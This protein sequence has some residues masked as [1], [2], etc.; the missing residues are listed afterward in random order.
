MPPPPPIPPCGVG[1]VDADDDSDDDGAPGFPP[2][3]GDA[4]GDTPALAALPSV[5]VVE[6]VGFAESF[7][8]SWAR[9]CAPLGPA[10]SSELFALFDTHFLSFSS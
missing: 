3:N 7:A 2:I 9:V 6:G 5:G 10:L 1:V 8:E 4:A